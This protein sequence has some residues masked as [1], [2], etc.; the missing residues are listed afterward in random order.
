MALL[1]PAQSPPRPPA[2]VRVGCY[3]ED[4]ER[5]YRVIDVVELQVELE[6]CLRPDGL[7][8]WLPVGE[9]VRTMRVVRPEG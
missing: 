8:Q 1:R 9:V 5:L 3:L 2:D 6:D 7:P 4:G